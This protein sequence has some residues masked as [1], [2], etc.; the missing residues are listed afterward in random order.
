MR[1]PRRASV[2]ALLASSRRETEAR[3]GVEVPRRS[4]HASRNA[5]A[6]ALPASPSSAHLVRPSSFGSLNVAPL[7][8]ALPHNPRLQRTTPAPL[9]DYPARSVRAVVAAEAPNRYAA[10]APGKCARAAR[11]F[12]PR[13]GLARGATILWRSLRGFRSAGARVSPAPPS[14]A[15][16]DRSS[17]V[18]SFCV[19]RAR[20]RVAA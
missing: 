1:Q 11:Q 10:T 8:G 9:V 16:L 2:L 19:G 6:P 7:G 17:A 3:D 20:M 13:N 18:V 4:P 14:S 12:A 15:H 5:N